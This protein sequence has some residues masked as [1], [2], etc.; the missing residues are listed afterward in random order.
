MGE[1]IDVGIEAAR[2]AGRF[3]LEN[4]GT[5]DLTIERK[6]DRSLATN[7][8]KASEQMIIDRIRRT[9][10][11]HGIIGEER[12]QDGDEQDYMWIIDPL[13][14]THNFIRGIPIFGVSIG[15]AYRDRFVAGVIYLPT[16]DRIYVGEQGNGAYCNGTKL[17][18]S[19]VSDLREC[20]VSFDSSLRSRSDLKLQMLRE[21]TSNSFNLRMLGASVRTLTYI[22]EGKIDATI[23]VED[24]SWD[25]AA[26]V[27]IV[28]EAGGR[29]SDLK[30]NPLTYRSIGYVVTN[31]IVHEQA[32]RALNKGETDR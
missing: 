9:F 7:V 28:E 31:G 19:S 18:V 25:F 16:E 22:A 14:G 32:I 12:G 6:V 11:G 3:L 23:E 2:E 27:C 20:T 10:P 8:D 30:G 21:V 29:S 15:V 17:Q 5:G 13:D 24:H 4:F 26:G 1:L